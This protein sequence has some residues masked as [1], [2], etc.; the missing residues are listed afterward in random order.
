MIEALELRHRLLIAAKLQIAA[1]PVYYTCCLNHL[2]YQEAALQEGSHGI[3][4][5]H[6]CIFVPNSHWYIRVHLARIWPLR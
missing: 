1:R 6:S 5:Q 3:K 4:T 2:Q